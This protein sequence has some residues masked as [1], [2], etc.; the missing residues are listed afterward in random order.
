MSL[1]MEDL[2]KR[3]LS[4]SFRALLLEEL[5]RYGNVLNTVAIVTIN[6]I[7]H[8]FLYILARSYYLK[9]FHNRLK[10]SLP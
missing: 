5:K 3:E 7:C 9:F 8:I 10:P 6:A 4:L 1:L 2:I